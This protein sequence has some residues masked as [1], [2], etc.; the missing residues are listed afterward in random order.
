MSRESLLLEHSHSTEAKDITMQF[1]LV[2]KLSQKEREI[3]EE[4]RNPFLP[5]FEE[6]P[7]YNN[8][9]SFCERIGAFPSSSLQQ[10][11]P[12]PT[13]LASS[14]ALILTPIQSFD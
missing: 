14:H 11:Q 8:I 12:L 1:L 4:V 13:T 10:V 2:S 5:P 3:N 7:P 6:V 9:G